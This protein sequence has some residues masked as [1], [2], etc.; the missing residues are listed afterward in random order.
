MPRTALIL[1]GLAALAL[2]LL[3]REGGAG[4]GAPGLARDGSSDPAADIGAVAGDG[5]AWGPVPGETRANADRRRSARQ[6]DCYGDRI[7]VRFGMPGATVDAAL[8]VAAWSHV[9]GD[10]EDPD[11]CLPVPVPLDETM[12]RTVMPA[13]FDAGPGA[14]PLES[15]ALTATGNA[16][17]PPG[18]VVRRRGRLCDV[19]GPVRPGLLL[20]YTADCA[21]RSG[22]PTVPPYHAALRAEV[23]D[24]LL[25]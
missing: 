21:D 16:A 4:P 9:L 25:D 15:L 2:V 13:P 5:S 17:L 12:T 1:W 24:W 7:P 23:A 6:R 22:T 11:R 3:L 14:P 10:E 8:P 20:G 19:V 18:P